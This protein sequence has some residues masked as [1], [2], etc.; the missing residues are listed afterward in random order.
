MTKEEIAKEIKSRINTDAK[1][2]DGNLPERFALAW[3]GYLAA[4]LEWQIIGIPQYDE[5]FEI[6]PE[7]DDPNPITT[8]FTG[9]D[10]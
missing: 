6:L 1:V 5:L 7:I 3:H 2:L 10:R 9:R 8:I 4:L